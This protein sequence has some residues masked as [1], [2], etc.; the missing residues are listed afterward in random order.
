MKRNEKSGG[1]RRR[2][3]VFEL[4]GH[5]V[6]LLFSF[7]FLMICT[8]LPVHHFSFLSLYACRYIRTERAVSNT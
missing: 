7:F 3:E 8:A 6:L 1:G 5:V 2:G 4:P